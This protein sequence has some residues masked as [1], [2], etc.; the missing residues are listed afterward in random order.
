MA[1]RRR[2]AGLRGHGG[3]ALGE[4]RGPAPVSRAAQTLPG[5]P[6]VPGAVRAGRQ[7]PAATR[8]STR[9]ESVAETSV[10]APE[11]RARR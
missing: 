10:K 7:M 3:T 9:S 11:A 2:G 4:R 6:P 1:G 8:R 5:G